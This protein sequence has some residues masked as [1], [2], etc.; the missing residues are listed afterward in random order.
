MR[1]VTSAPYSA[2]ATRN[3]RNALC[4]YG[5][6]L[7]IAF[8]LIDDT[9]D[10]TGDSRELGKPVGND[11]QEGKATLPF[12]F[13]LENAKPNEQA[14]LRE[15]FNTEKIEPA[16]FKELRDLVI[17]TGGIDYTQHQAVVHV[18]KAK[19]ALQI[20]PPCPTREILSDISDFVIVRRK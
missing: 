14:R 6:H 4:A 8:Q 16:D 13:A 11:I 1:H 19:A 3:G 18:E 9:L 2:A 17:R 20:F 10:Y 5:H 7:G 12:I 15:I